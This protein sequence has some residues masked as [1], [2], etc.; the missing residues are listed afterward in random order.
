MSFPN[1]QNLA[2]GAIPVWIAGAGG[3]G[4]APIAGSYQQITMSGIE[5]LTPPE[6]AVYAIIQAEA[7][8]LRYTD[9]GTNPTTTRGMQL[10]PGGSFTYNGD[11]T[12]LKFIDSATGGILN[13]LYYAVPSA[14]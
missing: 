13:V 11:L 12:K 3:I 8:L 7:S 5:V 4:Y 2:A 1:K 6:T 14:L 9:D 10:F